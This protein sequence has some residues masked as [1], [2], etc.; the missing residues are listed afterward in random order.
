M[1]R[2]LAVRLAVVVHAPEIVAV[3]HGRE[4]AVERQNFQAVAGKVEVANDFRPQQRDDVGANGKLES[5]ED[6]FG[7]G[8]A[9]EDVTAFE[10]EDFLA[11]AGEVGGVDE[12][13]VAAADDDDVVF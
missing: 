5:G 9:A 13:V 4:G 7:D 11:G 10:H 2:D 6:F 3:G 8:G 1:A 12:A